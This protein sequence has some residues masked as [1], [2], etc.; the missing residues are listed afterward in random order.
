MESA[1]RAAH[2]DPRLSYSDGC[3]FDLARLVAHSAG[4]GT[5]IAFA[6]DLECCS[7]QCVHGSDPLEGPLVLFGRAYVGTRQ[8]GD[9]YH[10]AHE[11]LITHDTASGAA[12]TF[13]IS[14]ADIEKK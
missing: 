7:S 12:R 11:W 6:D 2:K 9:P 4:W 10:N 1:A 13:D 14:A 3:I 8:A 5:R